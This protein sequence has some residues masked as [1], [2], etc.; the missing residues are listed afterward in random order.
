[1][2][3]LLPRPP[4][5]L[6]RN[7]WLRLPF[8][9]PGQF[10][11]HSSIVSDGTGWCWGGCS[12]DKSCCPKA[13]YPWE[14]GKLALA[15]SG[16]L[17]GLVES[18]CSL[19]WTCW[20]HFLFCPWQWVLCLAPGSVSGLL[21]LFIVMAPAW[22]FLE[23]PSFAAVWMPVLFLKCHPPSVSPLETVPSD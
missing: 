20:P 10:K 17:Q 2:E 6:C 19:S 21:F 18:P 1:M 11:L 16:R 13:Q 22:A 9:N 8:K 4:R 7:I 5:C 15:T 23:S 14:G 3:V 12:E